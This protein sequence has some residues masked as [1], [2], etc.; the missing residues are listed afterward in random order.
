LAGAQ[1]MAARLVA[2][3]E[4]LLDKQVALDTITL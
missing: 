1:G 3:D 2:V 4:E